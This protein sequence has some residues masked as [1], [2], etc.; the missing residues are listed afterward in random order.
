MSV[1][2]QAVHHTAH[3]PA[4]GLLGVVNRGLE[5]L[6]SWHDRMTYRRELSQLDDHMLEDLGLDRQ[7][8]DFE[9]RKPFWR[10]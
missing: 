2:R 5:V 4:H 10:G 8:V 7:T 3:H 6:S 9:I 1:H